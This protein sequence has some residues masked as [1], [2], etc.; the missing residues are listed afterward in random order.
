MRLEFSFYRNPMSYTLIS[1]SNEEQ[2][3]GSRIAVRSQRFY[4]NRRLFWSERC[5]ACIVVLKFSFARPL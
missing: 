3:N 4:F 5:D 1:A 2:S